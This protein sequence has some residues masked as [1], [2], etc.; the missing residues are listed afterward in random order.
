MLDISRLSSKNVTCLYVLNL[1]IWQSY[2]TGTDSNFYE[3]LL[4][5]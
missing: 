2:I 5:K 1:D 4:L 3:T